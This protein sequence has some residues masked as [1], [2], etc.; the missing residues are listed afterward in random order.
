MVT[1]AREV[2]LFYITSS[3]F[4]TGRERVLCGQGVLELMASL[5]HQNNEIMD[6]HYHSYFGDILK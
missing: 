5:Q 3:C 6:V 4:K 1:H 2:P